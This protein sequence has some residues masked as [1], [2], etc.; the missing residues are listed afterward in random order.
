MGGEKK[1]EKQ[2]RLGVQFFIPAAHA[3]D[4]N[5]ELSSIK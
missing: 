1:R 5:P 2:A 4:G 3:Y